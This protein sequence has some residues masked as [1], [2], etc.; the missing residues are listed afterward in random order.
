[1]RRTRRLNPSLIGRA[2]R[3]MVANVRKVR[4]AL[5][6]GERAGARAANLGSGAAT[7]PITKLPPPYRRRQH[8]APAGQLRGE[9]EDVLALSDRAGDPPLLL[10]PVAY[11]LSLR[12]QPR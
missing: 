2:G 10:D 11:L 8:S 12:V 6:P 3:Q 1:M 9:R 7:A 4:Q 5:S